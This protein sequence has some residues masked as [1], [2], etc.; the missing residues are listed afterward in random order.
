MHWGLVCPIREQL[1]QSGAGLEHAVLTQGL[2]YC[3]K[4]NCHHM[5]GLLLSHVLEEWPV[6]AKSKKDA[7]AGL[8]IEWHFSITIEH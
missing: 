6:G 5:S 7:S 2:N 1:K 4:E 8:F 3:I